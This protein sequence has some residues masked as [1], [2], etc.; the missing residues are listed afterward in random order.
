VNSQVQKT[1]DSI[2]EKVKEPETLRSVAELGLVKKVTLSD[3]AREILVTMDIAE[4]RL[5]CF[6][7]SVVNEKIRDTIQQRLK[8]E[9]EQEFPGYHCDFC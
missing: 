4:P 8:A 1:I 3:S 9:F 6:V 7:C 5:S 2:L